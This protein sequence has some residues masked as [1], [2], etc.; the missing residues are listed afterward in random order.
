MSAGFAA[1]ILD[2]LT[3]A[4][5]AVLAAVLLW[6][7]GT[8][9]SRAAMPDTTAPAQGV[10]VIEI[11]VAADELAACEAMLSAV[12]GA[13]AAAPGAE[14][15]PQDAQDSSLTLVSAEQQQQG[16]PVARCVAG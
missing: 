7:A 4:I 9:P 11:T 5:A 16:L 8:M 3:I 10:E 14:I 13:G 1:K 2:H 6:L 15:V 12:T